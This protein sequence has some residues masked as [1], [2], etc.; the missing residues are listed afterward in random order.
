MMA[1]QAAVQGVGQS[2]FITDWSL[3]VDDHPDTPPTTTEQNLPTE[4][5]PDGSSS[6][7]RWRKLRAAKGEVAA[8]PNKPPPEEAENRVSAYRR[9]ML[10]KGSCKCVAWL[11]RVI[12]STGRAPNEPATRRIGRR[13]LPRLL[14]SKASR[15]VNYHITPILTARANLS[16]SEQT[17]ARVI[18]E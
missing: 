9:S 4:Q 12:Q 3:W 17:N 16:R 11:A 6:S 18:S 15:N 5:Q 13:C 8:A 7:W 1:A 2:N 14:V 10:T